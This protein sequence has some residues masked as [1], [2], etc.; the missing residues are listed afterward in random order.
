[1][2]EAEAKENRKP[3]KYVFVK[4]SKIDE[5]LEFDVAVQKYTLSKKG[6]S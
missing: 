4:E 2:T 1:M 5:A 3:W 6:N